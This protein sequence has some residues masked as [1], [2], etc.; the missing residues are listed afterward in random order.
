MDAIRC[1]FQHHSSVDALVLDYEQETTQNPGS[2]GRSAARQLLNRPLAVDV[3]AISLDFEGLVA[4]LDPVFNSSHSRRSPLQ[5]QATGSSNPALFGHGG[6]NKLQPC[7]LATDAQRYRG[8]LVQSWS[9]G[10]G[11]RLLAARQPTLQS[12]ATSRT[13]IRDNSG[14]AGV[15]RRLA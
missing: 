7:S 6:P 8:L 11:F 12:Q 15:F 2:I 1:G 4:S 9:S 3:V 5:Y 14:P 10:A 13:K